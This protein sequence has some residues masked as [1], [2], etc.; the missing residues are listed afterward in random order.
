MTIKYDSV[1]HDILCFAKMI[2]RPFLAKEPMYVFAR[3]DRLSKVE[4]SIAMLIERGY[5][6]DCGDGLAQ[7]TSNG[8]DHV[9]LLA[10]QYGK[11]LAHKED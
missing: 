1:T 2:K 11:S 3:M 6:K 10:R 9:Y 7:I 8:R 4:R 5:L